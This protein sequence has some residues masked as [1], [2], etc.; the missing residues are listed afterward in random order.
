M[1]FFSPFDNTIEKRFNEFVSPQILQF[2]EIN[3]QYQCIFAN[4][5]TE[6]NWKTFNNFYI[7]NIE[8]QFLKVDIFLG[9]VLPF[10]SLP[11]GSRVLVFIGSAHKRICEGL[12][13]QA[14]T[15]NLA[16]IW[17]CFSIAPSIG[18]WCGPSSTHKSFKAC[19]R[20][21]PFIQILSQNYNICKSAW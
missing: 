6:R 15:P 21:Q 5:T 10:I 12:I 17:Q 14:S 2:S 11:I 9:T 13:I 3:Q 18:F 19:Y 4:N 20:Y 16:K 8:I 7:R 1:L